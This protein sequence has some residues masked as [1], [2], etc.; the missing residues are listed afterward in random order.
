M[1]YKNRFHKTTLGVDAQVLVAK[2]VEY[3]DDATLADFVAN[4]VEG[5]LAIVKTAD[6]SIPA[7]LGGALAVGTEVFFALKRDG[8]VEKTLPFKVGEVTKTVYVAPV[9]HKITVTS[10]LAAVAKGDI[11]ELAVIETTPGMQPLPT[12][13]YSV[14][15]KA[16]ETPAQAVARLVALINDATSIENSSRQ[17]VVTATVN[18]TVDIDIEAIRFGE[19]FTVALRGKLADAGSF[20]VAAQFKLGN[21]TPEQVA[22]AEA[23]GDI[24]KG[25]T[26][27]YPDQNATPEE[28]GKPTSFVD[29]AAQYASYVV[30]NFTEDVTRTLDKEFRKSYAFMFLP[31][32]GAANPYAEVNT[33]LAV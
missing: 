18:G 13:N 30:K 4:A 14:E 32:N 31:S 6:N 27:N 28:F 21:G 23:A 3:T 1:A 12:T 33:I 24:R 25:V 9:K 26:T 19:H 10:G 16:G 11:L 15:V 7:A 29:D 20:A 2:A 17:T 5:E 22:L 8:N